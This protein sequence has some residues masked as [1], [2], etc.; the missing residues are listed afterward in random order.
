M[1]LFFTYD[2]ALEADKFY[3]K[4]LFLFALK[5]FQKRNFQYYQKNFLFQINLR[6]NFNK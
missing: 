1:N 5:H 6:G 4:T 2:N 3:L